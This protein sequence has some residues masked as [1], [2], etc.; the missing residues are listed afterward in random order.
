MQN[1][2]IIDDLQQNFN[3]KDASEPVIEVNQLLVPLGVL[4]DRILGR[5]SDAGGDDDQHDENVKEGESDDG[6]DRTAKPILRGEDEHGGVGQ[7][8]GR[9]IGQFLLFLFC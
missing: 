9:G 3:G 7:Y 4:V 8:G 2:P 6:M 5:Q 1:N